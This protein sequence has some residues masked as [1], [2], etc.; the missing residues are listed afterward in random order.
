MSRVILTRRFKQTVI[1]Y[2]PLNIQLRWI[3]RRIKMAAITVHETDTFY[4]PERIKHETSVVL[5][6]FR[7]SVLGLSGYGI[8]K[9]VQ[10]LFRKIR[11]EIER[12][13]KIKTVN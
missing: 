2:T 11:N 12:F 4:A 5:S 1:S 9:R 10:Y 3:T 8:L 6:C 13:G 7:A